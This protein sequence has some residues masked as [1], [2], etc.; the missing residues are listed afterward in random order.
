MQ[1][2]CICTLSRY[3][4][5]PKAL[6]ERKSKNYNLDVIPNAAHNSNVDNPEKFNEALDSLL[7]MCV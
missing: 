6:L 1:W 7:N 5:W 4:E 3:F 2:K